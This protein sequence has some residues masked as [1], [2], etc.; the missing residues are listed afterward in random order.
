MAMVSRMP[1]FLC[2]LVI[3]ISISQSNAQPGFLYHFCINDKGNYSA[4]S[5]YQNNLNTLLSNLSSNTQIDYGFYNFSYGQE[6]DRVNAIGL[7]RGD[8][9]PDACRICFNDSK[10]LLTQLCPNQKEAIG[11]YDNCMLRY[12]NR[13]I[14]N[15]MEALPSFSMRNHGNT[16]D[17]DQ[18]NQVLRTLLYSLVGQGSSGDSRHK[19]AAANVSGPGFETIYG[20]VQCTPD[21]SE[22]ECTS[23]LVDAISEIPRCCDSKK[24]G[25][26]VRP[27]CNFR[28]ETYP[29]YTPTNV[30]IP[31][32]PAPKVSA[33]PPSSTDTLSP[34][35]KRELVIVLKS[36]FFLWMFIGRTNKIET[37]VGG[38]LFLELVNYFQS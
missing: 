24:G 25:R 12:S 9:K 35:G 28:Y 27:S 4:N 3:L 37:L 2:I 6:S 29:F 33:L 23:C 14:F 10:V 13:S 1:I 38:R 34:E 22:Q 15:T 36:S 19:F 18:F 32:A 8:V 31:Q 26:V 7:C 17:V 5:T 11:W 21:L 16:T 20:L 30:A